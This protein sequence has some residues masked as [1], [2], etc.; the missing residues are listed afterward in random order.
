MGGYCH[1]HRKKLGW[2]CPACETAWEYTGRTHLLDAFNAGVRGEEETTEWQA[3]PHHH[4]AYLHGK[5]Y[6]TRQPGSDNHKERHSSVPKWQREKHKQKELLMPKKQTQLPTA[7]T[8][9]S[10]EQM[11]GGATISADAAKE[12]RGAKPTI[13]LD[14][15]QSAALVKMLD[16]KR[17]MKVAEGIMR[18]EE[19]P[20]LEFC[21]NRQDTDGLAG[22]FSGSYTV[23]SEDGKTKATFITQDKFSIPADSVDTLKVMLGDQFAVEVKTKQT[24]TLKPEVFEDANLKAELVKLIGTNFSKFF[25]TVTTYSAK[26]GFDERLYKLAGNTANVQTLRTLCGK[27]KPY[28][29]Q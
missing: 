16:A 19:G 25:Q 13:K 7:N 8:D 20:L 14:K 2:T 28:I 4:A 11:V 12:K 10:F 29:K 22:D 18:S 6:C 27:S 24:V 3:D 26:E 15:T 5:E 21:L 17:D 9:L 1:E 23:L